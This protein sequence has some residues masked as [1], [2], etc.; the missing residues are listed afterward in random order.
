[1]N[2]ISSKCFQ[3]VRKLGSAVFGL[4]ALALVITPKFFNELLGLTSAPGL[5]RL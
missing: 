5:G 4:S 1:M 3:L 2:P